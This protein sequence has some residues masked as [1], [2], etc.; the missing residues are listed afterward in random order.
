VR[1]VHGEGEGDELL[2]EEMSTYTIN[3]ISM[4]FMVC[5]G[6]GVYHGMPEA[7]HRKHYKEGK[8]SGG[9]RC[10]N[11]CSRIYLQGED[12]IM[13]A[14]MEALRQ[15]RDRAVQAK[16]RV[17]DERDHERRR[18]AAMKGVATRIKNRIEKG[19]CP[20]CN[21]TFVDLQRHM[22]NKHPGEMGKQIEE[23]T[24]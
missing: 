24:A 7:L 1:P 22:M 13:K 15:Q 10:P 23:A 19:V 21:R 12:E 9:W 2:E 16:A 18:A 20:C 6:C 14:E 3:G 8:K 4:Y 11:G 17:E 5:G